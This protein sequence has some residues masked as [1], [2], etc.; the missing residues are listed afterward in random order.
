MK[1]KK[2]VH[3][4]TFGQPQGL[5]GEFKINI[6]TSSFE[7]FKKLKQY[8]IEDEKLA[9]TFKTLRF[10]GKKV[11]GSIDGCTDRD[12]A[13]LL[14]GKFIFSLRENF[15]KININEYYIVDLIDCKV[16]DIN[17][18][19]IGIVADIENFGAGDLIEVYCSGKNSFY[20]PMNNDNLV[21]VD[22]VN[23]KIIVNPIKGLLE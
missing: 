10:V 8:F 20:I 3:V 17:N 15:P 9:L 1:E 16:I 18:K 11:I 14:K 5:K 4:G 23:K 22:I 19:L 7:S 6:F 12:N 2:L 13:L 21:S